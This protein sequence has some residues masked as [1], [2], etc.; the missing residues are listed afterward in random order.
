MVVTRSASSTSFTATS[1]PLRPAAVR[2]SPSSVECTVR[3]S[4][5]S[6]TMASTSIR[7]QLTPPSACPNQCEGG[8]WSL[9]PTV[10][11][12]F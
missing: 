9:A 4:P 3:S 11:S 2:L 6:A 12:V 5:S 8:D 10:V 1:P 7:S